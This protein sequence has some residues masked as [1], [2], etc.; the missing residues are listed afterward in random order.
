MIECK[1]IVLLPC[2]AKARW[3]EEYKDLNWYLLVVTFSM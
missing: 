3:V 1:I 2:I